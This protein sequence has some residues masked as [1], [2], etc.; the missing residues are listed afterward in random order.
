M[1]EENQIESLDNSFE[2]WMH[3]LSL[4]NTHRGYILMN[5]MSTQALTLYLIWMFSPG[6]SLW[7]M[8]ILDEYQSESLEDIH[9]ERMH[10]QPDTL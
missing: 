6:A 10:D 9:L 4:G 1:A 5:N 7:K 8:I 3:D 2:I